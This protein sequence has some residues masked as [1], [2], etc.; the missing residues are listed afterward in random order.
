MP[1]RGSFRLFRRVRL[2]FG[3][4]FEDLEVWKLVD[5]RGGS[6]DG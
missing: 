2:R 1:S 5:E 6:L 4:I 3:D